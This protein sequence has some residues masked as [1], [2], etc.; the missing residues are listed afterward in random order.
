MCNHICRKVIPTC[1]KM[2]KQE[3]TTSDILIPLIIVIIL[4]FFVGWMLYLLIESGF[5]SSS[6]ENPVTSDKRG[7]F[8]VT[9]PP[10]QCATDIFSGFKTCPQRGSSIVIDPAQSVC[11]SRTLCD[12]P[13][14]PFAVQSDGSTNIEGVCEANVACPCLK[15]SQC[16]NYVLSAFNSSNGNAYIGLAGQRILFPQTTTFVS[17]N[18]GVSDQPPIQYSDPGTT[19]CFA[20]ISWLPLSNPGCNFV[21]TADNG[22]MT[23]NDLLVCMGQANGCDGITGNACLQGTLAIVTPNPDTLSQ[24]NIGTAQYACVAGAPCPCGFVTV[25]DTN[26]GGVVCRQL[27]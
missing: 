17:T 7:T 27:N 5:K 9:C 8:S 4:I 3:E 24:A 22:T 6:V 15:V 1:S 12:N 2:V 23:Y 21:S 19:F 18:G 16:P 25:Y 20:P 11:N 13:L 14:T 10:D 26:Y